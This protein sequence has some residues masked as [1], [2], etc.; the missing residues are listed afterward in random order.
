MGGLNRVKKWPRVVERSH[1]VYS[2]RL[3]NT[4]PQTKYT[5]N[6]RERDGTASCCDVKRRRNVDV[7]RR[8]CTACNISS[9]CAASCV[10]RPSGCGT[11]G[12]DARMDNTSA[13]RTMFETRTR[14]VHTSS[15]VL[16][17]LITVSV[18][19]NAVRTD[20]LGKLLTIFYS[21]NKYLKCL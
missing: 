3:S 10:S 12:R 18:G 20:Y 8:E 2:M 14:A 5:T 21:K 9:E 4:G 13:R 16:V 6:L 7:E 1:H 11:K 19:P 17:L 15:L